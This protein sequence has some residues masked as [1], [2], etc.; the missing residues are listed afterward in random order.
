MFIIGIIAIL[1][2]LYGLS[3]INIQQ[4]LKLISQAS[5]LVMIGFVLCYTFSEAGNKGWGSV[6]ILE[7]TVC[8]WW[9]I[10]YYSICIKRIKNESTTLNL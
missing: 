3:Y 6:E 1:V 9:Y 5:F 7:T 8:D 10:L 2:I 4:T